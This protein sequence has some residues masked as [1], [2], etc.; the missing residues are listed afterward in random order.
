MTGEKRNLVRP[1]IHAEWESRGYRIHASVHEPDVA[2]GGTW[3]VFSHGFTSQRL[4]PEYLHV[5]IARSL[6]ECGA[7]CVRFDF[8]GAG[9]SDGRFDEMT[10]STMVADLVRAASWVRDRYA[11]A[12]LVLLGH[13]LGGTVAAMAASEAAADGLILLAPVARPL[14]LAE[15]YR[16]VMERGV[17]GDGYYE[18]G[19][20][21]MSLGFLHDLG[22]AEP[23]RALSACACPRIL[24]LHGSEDASVPVGESHLYVDAMRKANRDVR[25]EVVPGADHRVLSV[26]GRKRICRVI[27]QW[28]EVRSS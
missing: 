18:L 19:A 1:I 2:E 25:F 15:G 16:A 22:D 24:V 12:R 13:S 20:H 11:P 8:A 6:A 9:E 7:G 26:A 4:G 17:N 3:V 23:V 14:K 5:G 10:V 21:E 27:I 28:L